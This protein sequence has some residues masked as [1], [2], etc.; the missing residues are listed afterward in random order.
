MDAVLPI[1]D[2][3][4][5]SGIYVHYPFCVKK[6]SYCDFYSEGIGS[7]PSPFEAPLFRAYE[8]EIL[9]R[10]AGDRSGKDL[11]FDTIFFGG[12]T[13]SKAAPERIAKF[14]LF[15]KKNLPIE[16]DAEIT[17]ECNPE[18]LNP[19]LLQELHDAGINRAHVGIQSYQGTHLNF[20]DRFYDP[21]TY[22]RVL[23]AFSGSS[24]RNFGAD[25]MFGVPGQREEEFYSDM[26]RIL[27]AGV[28]HISLYALTVEKGTDYSRKVSDGIL[29]AP[30][31]EIQERILRDLPEILRKRDFFQYEVSNYS[32]PGFQ[33]RHNLKYW[34]YEYYLGIGPGAHG[35]LPQGRYANARNTQ[36]YLKRKEYGSYEIPSPF[37]E[38]V[39]SLF[40]IFLPIRLDGF[41]SLIPE[42]AEELKKKL[43]NKSETGIATWDG[44]VFRWKPE[45]VLFLDSE[46]LD[47]VKG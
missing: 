5:K 42:R 26:E 34:T 46:I 20:L 33:S 40:R 32:K 9:H 43:R 19:K 41:L 6:C 24:I 7:E 25:L 11:R 10:I 29:P 28:S 1:L 4:G 15:L 12:G 30:E 23:D 38:I 37:E 17:L 3:S 44:S 2:K 14:I 8:E 27:S 36:A 18:D 45:A 47:L 39:L 21:E 22:S 13:P 35:F 31:E 16:K